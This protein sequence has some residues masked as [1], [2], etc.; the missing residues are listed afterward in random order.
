MRQRQNGKQESGAAVVEAAIYFPIVIC[1][2]MAMLYLGL[3]LLQEAAMNCQLQR[4]TTYASKNTSNPGYKV[5][6][7]STGSEFEFSYEG[8]APSA[9]QVDQ[10]YMAYHN[11]IGALYRGIAGLFSDE[12]Y[13]YNS[14]LADMANHGLLFRFHVSPS[15]E[16]EKTLF[17][18]SIVATVEYSIPTP[19]A[20]RYLGLNQGLVIRSASYCHA[21][22][23]SGFVRNTDLAVDLVEFAADKLGISDTITNIVNQAKEKINDL[24]QWLGGD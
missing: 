14:M 2:V 8:N 7:F 13:D 17:G 21:V 16:V 20:I 18:T 10:Y 19:G 11:D 3:F 4:F 15:V 24:R 23:P 1:V 6:P 5:F 12:D 22:D 9:S